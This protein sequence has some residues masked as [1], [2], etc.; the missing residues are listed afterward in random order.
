MLGLTKKVGYK[1]NIRKR[2]KSREIRKLDITNFPFL[3]F[4]DKYSLYQGFANSHW[5]F[6]PKLPDKEARGCI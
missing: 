2:K 1:I 3:H 4:S 5:E 6:L